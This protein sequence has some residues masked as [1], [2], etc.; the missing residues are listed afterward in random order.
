MFQAAYRNKKRVMKESSLIERNMFFLYFLR[1]REKCSSLDRSRP[2]RA[3]IN[4]GE[5]SKFLNERCAYLNRN[6]SASQKVKVFNLPF[7][8]HILIIC[9]KRR[10][11]YVRN[12]KIVSIFQSI[13]ALFKKKVRLFI[14]NCDKCTYYWDNLNWTSVTHDMLLQ[15]S[16]SIGKDIKFFV[17][18]AKMS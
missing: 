3:T 5:Q 17:W 8:I 13:K 7:F 10:F 2:K 1:S 12:M 9:W 4:L 11:N 15:K 16:F 14:A 6:L 18:V